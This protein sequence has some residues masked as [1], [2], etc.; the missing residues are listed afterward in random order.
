MTREQAKLIVDQ[1]C[2]QDVLDDN[3]EMASLQQHAPEVLRALRALIAYA[4]GV[5][6]P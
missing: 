3:E 6:E 4:E 5:E 2:I 1:Y